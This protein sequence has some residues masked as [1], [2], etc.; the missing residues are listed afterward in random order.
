V[1]E[2][3][4]RRRG[5]VFPGDPRMNDLPELMLFDDQTFRKLI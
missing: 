5:D 4:T 3:H 2:E 1:G